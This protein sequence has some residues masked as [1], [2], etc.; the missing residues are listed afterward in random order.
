MD[1][2]QKVDE[3][4]EVIHLVIMFMFRVK[5]IKTSKM[6]LF[7]GL[8]FLLSSAENTKSEQFLTF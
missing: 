3:K 7:L 4:N 1:R 8:F 2:A 5:V 6:T